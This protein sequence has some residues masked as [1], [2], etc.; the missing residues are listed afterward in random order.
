MQT[1]EIA[2]T[3]FAA[4]TNSEWE[5]SSLRE[6][7]LLRKDAIDVLNSLYCPRFDK[8]EL[9]SEDVF[10]FLTV[11]RWK[12]ATEYERTVFDNAV[13]LILSYT[14]RDIPYIRLEKVIDLDAYKKRS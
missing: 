11:K 1:Q 8:D 5:N 10:D 6:R 14:P 3:Q 13:R 4:L 7:E 9:T 2:I 12:D